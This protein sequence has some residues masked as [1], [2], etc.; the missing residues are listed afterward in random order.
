[1]RLEPHTT[2]YFPTA[3]SRLRISIPSRQNLLKNVPLPNLGGNLYTFNPVETPRY[4]AGTCSRRSHHQQQRHGL[5]ICVL[6]TLA[7]HS[8]ASVPRRRLCLAIG[9]NDTSFSTEA[10]GAWTHTFSPTTL[11]EFRV[12]FIRFNYQAV[13]PTNIELPSSLGFTG[14]T[15]AVPGRAPV[16]LSISLTGYF[17]LGFSPDGPQPAVDNT[18]QIDDNFSKVVG[19]HTLKF[20]FD[21]RRYE[22]NNPFE[23]ENNGNFSFGGSGTYSTGDPGADFLLGIPDSYRTVQR[24][25][26]ELPQL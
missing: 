2:F 14:I 17:N 16:R 6:A 15:S 24:R 25:L 8:H 7:H 9:E 1:M 18:Y 21:G 11:N 3:R 12:S 10:V 20:G 22:V 5:G 23:Y 13:T 4:R 19:N 26:P